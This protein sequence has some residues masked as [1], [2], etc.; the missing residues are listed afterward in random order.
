MV[1][2][3]HNLGFPNKKNALRLGVFNNQIAHHLSVP[4]TAH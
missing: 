4:N 1:K 2:I 3:A